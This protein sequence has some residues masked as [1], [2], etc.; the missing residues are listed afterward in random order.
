M[1]WNPPEL[2]RPF[3]KVC[4]VINYFHNNAKTL[5]AFNALILSQLCKEHIM[6]DDINS[7]TANRTYAVYF[8][9]KNLSVLISNTGYIDR[10]NVCRLFSF[11]IIT[12]C[13]CI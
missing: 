11:L 1:I 4:K 3:W 13:K 7:L 9:F 5:F 6:Y 10:Y 8:C 2:L 12:K